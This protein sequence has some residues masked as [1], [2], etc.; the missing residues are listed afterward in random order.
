MQPGLHSVDIIRALLVSSE[1]L[2]DFSAAKDDQPVSDDHDSFDIKPPLPPEFLP[3]IS[4]Y[5]RWTG[6][7]P[8]VVGQGS[9]WVLQAAE[10]S[11]AADFGM[12][13]AAPS[14]KEEAEQLLDKL[15]A[16]EAH[17]VPGSTEGQQ[18]AE[19]AHQR[20]QELAESGE[21]ATAIAKYEGAA[22]HDPSNLEVL[23]SLGDAHF[24]LGAFQFE[25]HESGAE[26][27]FRRAIKYDPQHTDALICARQIAKEREQE[28]EQKALAAD[29]KTKQLFG[30]DSNDDSADT[31][32]CFD[33]GIKHAQAGDF[34]GA[35]TAF[36][37]V[38][39]LEGL[40]MVSTGDLEG[41]L[42]QYSLAVAINPDRP[43]LNCNFGA[44][45]RRSRKFDC[46]I[47]AY[48]RA[49]QTAASKIDR[50]HAFCGLGLTLAKTGD[51][52][53]AIANYTSCIQL[54]QGHQDAIFNR[55][56]AH[57]KLVRRT[58]DRH[59]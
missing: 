22:R 4:D 25:N 14:S 35:I 46:A 18:L 50:A 21:Y 2:A 7:N 11:T 27:S 37:R 59:S 29:E 40:A 36:K 41:G 32:S 34:A 39:T 53:G 42:A 10:D 54:D 57:R 49:L 45:L 51:L 48:R 16:V 5:K 38:I 23:V 43:S 55:D 30:R 19:I 26:D 33:E 3:E 20:G 1:K 9:P 13:F 12:G 28:E 56:V 8:N 47:Q 31:D 17:Y 58:V 44:A 6:K 52:A 15:L 24:L